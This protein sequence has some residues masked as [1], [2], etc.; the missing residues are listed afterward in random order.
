[1]V[2][3]ALA[4]LDASHADAMLRWMQ[5]PF[6]AENLGLRSE[7]SLEK[8]HDFIRRAGTD[9]TI[10]A[11]AILHDGLHVG[12]VVLDSIDRFA[13]KARLHIYVG[14]A[15]ARGCGVAKRAVRLAL[16]L[17]F[18][19]LGLDKVWLTVHAGNASARAVYLAAGFVEEGVHREEF[20]LR[21]ERVDAIYMGAHRADAGRA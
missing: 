8:T 2:D 1:V 6:V 3:V 13:S 11:R 12:N 7:P 14:E 18:G 15:R 9:P 16:D 20:L 10:A 5:D 4:P 19:D 17:A 21:G